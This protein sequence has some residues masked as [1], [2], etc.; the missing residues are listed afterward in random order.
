MK[1]GER[2][3]EGERMEA[4]GDAEDRRSCIPSSCVA[5]SVSMNAGSSSSYSPAVDARYDDIFVLAAPIFAKWLSSLY[6]LS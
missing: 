4:G 2:K 6:L 3:E 5:A 1:K